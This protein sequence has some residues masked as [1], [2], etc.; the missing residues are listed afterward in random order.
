MTKYFK[1]KIFVQDK[2]AFAT[3]SSSVQWLVA[4][5]GDWELLML[6]TV[7]SNRCGEILKRREHWE[8]IEWFEMKIALSAEQNK[9]IFVF[10]LCP[11]F[12]F[13]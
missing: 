10:S 3:P 5:P 1:N 9:L 7:D 13:P 2:K 11:V 12:F 6:Q 8:E 4:L